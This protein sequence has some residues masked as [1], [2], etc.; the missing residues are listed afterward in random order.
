ML[1]CVSCYSRGFYALWKTNLFCMNSSSW[2]TSL[3]MWPTQWPCCQSP[4]LSH[5]VHRLCTQ[6]SL[7]WDGNVQLKDLFV[8]LREDALAWLRLL[9]WC[10]R[11]VLGRFWLLGI[12]WKQVTSWIYKSF[13]HFRF[14]GR[15]RKAAAT[16]TD[17][18]F[19][20]FLLGTVHVREYYHSTCYMPNALLV[21]V[22]MINI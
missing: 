21:N 10:L 5:Y 19:C 16:N 9:G 2:G 18:Y 14:Q 7:C 20:F 13:E 1:I 12:G 4:Q 15:G 11:E 6:S 22:E 3:A 17:L 8:Q